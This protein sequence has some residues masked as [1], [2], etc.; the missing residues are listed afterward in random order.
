M[1]DEKILEAA[2]Q[3]G[4]DVFVSALPEGY[5]TDVGEAGRRLS[6]GERQRIALARALLENPPILLLDEPS[7]NLD[8]DAEHQLCQTLRALS[9]RHN[10]IVVSHA[11]QLL[12]ACDDIIALGR[13]GVVLVGPSKDVLPRLFPLARGPIAGREQPA[14]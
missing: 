14:A 13:R 12:E 9:D 2:R 3:A 8:P 11:P 4:V 5:D 1:P 10:L 7:A 6:G